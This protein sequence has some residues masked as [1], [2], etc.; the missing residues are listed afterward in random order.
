MFQEFP[1]LPRRFPGAA[2]ESAGKL[3]RSSELPGA[4]RLSIG[5]AMAQKPPIL[6]LDEPTAAL[7][8]TCK[9]QIS[10]YLLHYKQSGGLL[11]LTTH[12]VM[13]LDLCDEWYIM[14]DGILVPFQFDGNVQRLVESL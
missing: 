5:C 2:L 10:S 8:L 6:L 9:Q 4:E 13:E 1:P 14:R 11:L 12:D 7:D 3:R